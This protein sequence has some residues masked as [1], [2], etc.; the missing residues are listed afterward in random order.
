MR[1]LKPTL[2]AMAMLPKMTTSF[3]GQMLVLGILACG[4]AFAGDMRSCP[5]QIQES[6][7]DLRN[8]GADWTTFVAAPLYLHSVTVTDGPPER[9]GQ[10]VGRHV[11]TGRDAWTD[12]YDLR[13]PYPEGKWLQCSYGM[14]NEIVLAKRLEDSITRCTIR[15]KK[16]DKA[17]QNVFSVECR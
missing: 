7:V 15:G 14:L 4:P 10:L 13:G 5:P 11:A 1:I 16:G 12:T 6:S 17:G 2:R 9:L 8:V 3:L